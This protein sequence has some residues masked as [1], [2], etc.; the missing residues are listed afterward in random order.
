[1][2]LLEKIAVPPNY[3]G[4]ALYRRRLPHDYETDQPVF[5]TWRLHDSLARHRAFPAAT[6]HSGQAFAAMDRLLD[7][8]RSGPSYLRQPAIADMVAEAIQYNAAN[9]E[10]YVL[11]AFVVM[12]NHVHLLATPTLAL[13]KLTKSLKG[14]TSKRANPTFAVATSFRVKTSG[15]AG[16]S[17]GSSIKHFRKRL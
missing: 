17:L 12:P 5:L 10:H 13:P 1:M 4:M 9:L 11:H 8:A 6:V 16:E 15:S 2:F 7:G 3:P 14:I